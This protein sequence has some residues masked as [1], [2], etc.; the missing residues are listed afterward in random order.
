LEKNYLK[1]KIFI[2]LDLMEEN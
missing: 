1:I 2:R